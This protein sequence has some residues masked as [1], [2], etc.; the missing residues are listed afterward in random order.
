MHFCQ[1]VP[2]FLEWG[3]GSGIFRP[4]PTYDYSS[5]PTILKLG[6]VWKIVVEW[7]KLLLEKWRTFWKIQYLNREVYCMKN[8]SDQ[9]G[10]TWARAHCAR[11]LHRC[12]KSIVIA[13]KQP[14]KKLLRINDHTPPMLEFP[15]NRTKWQNQTKMKPKKAFW[16]FF[17]ANFKHLW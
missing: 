9:W 17:F 12:L 16:A 11:A 5:K 14:H 8:C 1:C 10:L 6:H 3:E 13:R 2:V 4:P 15:I 7:W